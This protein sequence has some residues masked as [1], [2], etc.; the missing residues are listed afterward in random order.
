[1][2]RFFAIVLVIVVIVVAISFVSYHFKDFKDFFANPKNFPS[3]GSF[4]RF[5]TSSFPGIDVPVSTSSA[6]VPP[7]GT[8]P[9]RIDPKDIPVGFTEKDLSPHFKKVRI[10]SFTPQSGSSPATVELKADMA[11]GELINLAGWFIKANRGNQFIPSA[12]RTYNPAEQKP[13]QSIILRK[14]ESIK[15]YPTASPVGRNLLLNKCMG[16]LNRDFVFSPPLPGE[17][18][19]IR[20]YDIASLTGVCQDYILALPRCGKASSSAMVYQTDGECRTYLDTLAYSG[21]LA[22]HMGESD[23]FGSEWWVWT[24]HRFLDEKHDR[25]FLLDKKGFIVDEYV[26]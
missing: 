6:G 8:P 10:S 12:T 14:G 3:P 15:L 22:H 21:C 7:G 9:R 24:G 5:G 23:F 26:Y 13:E 11:S 19:E 17:C 25:L 2:G 4:F 16:Y 1:M 20:K 18:P